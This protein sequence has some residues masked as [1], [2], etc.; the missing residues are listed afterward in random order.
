[1]MKALQK[2]IIADFVELDTGQSS[3]FSNC[4][5][6]YLIQLNAVGFICV[7]I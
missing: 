4:L 6:S 2:K 7:W 1:M 3:L 5:L